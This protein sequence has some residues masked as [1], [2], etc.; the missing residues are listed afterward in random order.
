M[1]VSLWPGAELSAN[2]LSMVSQGEEEN[3]RT[4]DKVPSCEPQVNN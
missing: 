1:M 3:I 4:E 2:G